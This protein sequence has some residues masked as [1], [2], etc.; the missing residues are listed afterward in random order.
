MFVGV[1]GEEWRVVK[2]ELGGGGFIYLYNNWRLRVIVP[3]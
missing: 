2:L 3:L 1:G